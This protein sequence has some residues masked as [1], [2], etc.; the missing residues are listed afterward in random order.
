M[1]RALN[2]Y[3]TKLVQV[4]RSTISSNK[5][6]LE[7]FTKRKEAERFINLFYQTEQYILPGW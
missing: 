5:K 3:S 1:R 2:I 7:L 4:Q 6:K